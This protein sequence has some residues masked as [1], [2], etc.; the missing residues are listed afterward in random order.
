MTLLTDKT[1]WNSKDIGLYLQEYSRSLHPNHMLFIKIKSKLCSLPEFSR[2]QMEKT[3]NHAKMEQKIKILRENLAV[4]EKIIPGISSVKGLILYDIHI[5]SFIPAQQKIEAIG[6]E[7]ENVPNDLKVQVDKSVRILQ[8]CLDHLSH[9]QDGTYENAIFKG[10]LLG[11]VRN[12]Q[13]VPKKYHGLLG[14]YRNMFG[15]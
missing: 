1:K 4:I 7:I 9:D 5:A 10:A 8:Q 2:E 14:E 12:G 3:K 11:L 13:E 15:L 6:G